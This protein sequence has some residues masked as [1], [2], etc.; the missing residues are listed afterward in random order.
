[1]ALPEKTLIW[2]EI[3]SK[4]GFQER[5]KKGL[6]GS[7]TF[8]YFETL[9]K[10]RKKND[11]VHVVVLDVHYQLPLDTFNSMTALGINSGEILIW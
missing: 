1:M 8:F 6:R 2:S 3:K 7:K 9:P 10:E 11:M 5:R 4:G